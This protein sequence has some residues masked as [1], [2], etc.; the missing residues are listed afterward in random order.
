[1]ERFCVSLAMNSAV[2]AVGGRGCHEATASPAALWARARAIPIAEVLGDGVLLVLAGH[3]RLHCGSNSLFLRAPTSVVYPCE[4]SLLF[5]GSTCAPLRWRR[6][7]R[8]LN[9]TDR[10]DLHGRW[11]KDM[12]GYL[13]L[14]F[15]LPVRHVRDGAGTEGVTAAAVPWVT[16]G[17]PSSPGSAAPPRPSAAPGAAHGVPGSWGSPWAAAVRVLRHRAAGAGLRSGRTRGRSGRGAAG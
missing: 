15:S 6:S 2:R 9:K 8:C 14:K 12:S 17:G 3:W 4:A 11:Q 1:M 13:S 10:Q 5:V 16:G 7:S